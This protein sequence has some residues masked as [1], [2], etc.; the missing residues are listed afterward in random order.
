[1]PGAFW[2]SGKEKGLKVSGVFRLEHQADNF[3]SLTNGKGE[4]LK[5]SEQKKIIE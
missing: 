3:Q 2:G 5:V 4:Q 1:M